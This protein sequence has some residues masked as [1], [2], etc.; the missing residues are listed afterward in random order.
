M[1]VDHG[2]TDSAPVGIEDAEHVARVMSALATAS[3][4]RI[5]AHLR[6][7]PASVGELAASVELAQPAVSQHL[8]ILRDLGIVT[9]DRNGRRTVYDLYDD[10]VLS[11]LDEAL[12]HVD[13]VRAG[14]PAPSLVHPS[15]Q[16]EK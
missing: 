16:P 3:R 4:V 15:A 6:Q 11:L 7:G 5:L 10:H 14:E 1:A 12:S 9:A 2:V 8:R 13:H